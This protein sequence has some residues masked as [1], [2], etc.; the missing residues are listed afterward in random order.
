M[1][2]RTV[3]SAATAVQ[4]SRQGAFPSALPSPA[5][6]SL[7]ASVQFMGLPLRSQDYDAALTAVPRH[8]LAL[9][10]KGQALAAQKKLEVSI[11][12]VTH[13]CPCACCVVGVALWSAC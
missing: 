9:Y 12:G 7:Q 10:R 1:Q 8:C 4:E 2:P 5:H 3:P 13:L 11:R 6:G